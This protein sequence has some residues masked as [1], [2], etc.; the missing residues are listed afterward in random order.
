MKKTISTLAVFT[1]VL[2]ALVF[3]APTDAVAGVC[4]PGHPGK[5]KMKGHLFANCT[6]LFGPPPE[7]CYYFECTK[8]GFDLICED[9]SMYSSDSQVWEFGVGFDIPVNMTPDVEPPQESLLDRVRRA[10]IRWP[11]PLR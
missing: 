5:G 7:G 8:C 2:G 9:G 4:D 3:L 11:V 10:W 6:K 1:M